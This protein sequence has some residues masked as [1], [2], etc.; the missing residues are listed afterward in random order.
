MVMIQSCHLVSRLTSLPTKALPTLAG[1]GQPQPLLHFLTTS[2]S[3]GLLKYQC[4]VDRYYCVMVR[5]QPNP[6]L[7]S[8]I[9]TFSMGLYRNNLQAFEFDT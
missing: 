1:R 8:K 7:H 5:G 4:L 9:G 3:T 6:S 2:H